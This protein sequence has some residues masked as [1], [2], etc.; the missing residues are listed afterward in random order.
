MTLHGIVYYGCMLT[1]LELSTL[2]AVY[3]LKLIID[4]LKETNH[5][6][7]S[8]I[9]LFL[10]FTG[11][12][13]VQLLVRCYYDLHVYNYYRFVQTKVQCWLFDLTCSL[14]QWQIKE[15]KHA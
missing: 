15:E 14:K 13:V 6:S 5:V 2:G 11:F 8:G 1:V 7:N 4:Y 10:W 12:R 9:E 3:L